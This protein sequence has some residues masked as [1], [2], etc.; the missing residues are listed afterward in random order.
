MSH[1]ERRV[2]PNGLRVVSVP[3]HDTQAL[4]V[5]VLFE[6]G[7]RY[8]T[9]KLAG[10][11]HF[12]EHM[13]FKGTKRR[14]STTQISRELDAVG[15]DYNAFTA[16]DFTGYYIHLDGAH[17]SMA[18]DMLHDV[19]CHSTF[20]AEECERERKVIAEEINMYEDNPI[21]HAEELLEEVLYQ[22]SPLGRV[23]SGTHETMNGIDRETLVKYYAAHYVPSRTVVAV[24]GRIEP[25][26][27]EAVTDLFGSIP[28]A[29]APKAY[30]RARVRTGRPALKIKYKETEQVLAMIGFPGYPYGHKK[31]PALSVL[32]TAL[33]G[34]MSSRL[35][36]QVRERRGLAYS[37]SADASRFQDTG[38]VAIFAGLTKA[39]I[40]DGLKV[41]MN[42]L[43]KVA[44]S[45]LTAK[46]LR[47]SKD[48]IKGKT[49]LHLET[50]SALAQYYAMQELMTGR[51]VTP[52]E[53]MTQIEAVTLADVQA[54]AAELFQTKKLSASI[55]GPYKD[56]K[57]FLP[58]LKV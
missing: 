17:G 32:L 8:E 54:V 38:N 41:I 20:K 10:A 21:M 30:E 15:A 40:E 26:V 34:G 19:L 14:P 29:K 25:G 44:K 18:V 22:G 50:S 53:K 33:G 51:F 6:V 12:I 31:L 42:E 7:S 1:C 9:E 56:P 46:E 36:T 28:A 5:L 57:Q 23:I 13:M 55:I 4:T 48:Y 2:L 27:M 3:A 52:E 45:G 35:F 11:S 49:V 37:V 58:L 39:K 43:T 16:K 24:A 47:R